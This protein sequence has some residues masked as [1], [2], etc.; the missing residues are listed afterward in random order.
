MK[1]WYS[2]GKRQKTYDRLVQKL[3]PD[4]GEAETEA[5]EM[6]RVMGNVVYDVGNNGGCNFDAGG[7]RRSDLNSF[8]DFLKNFKFAQADSLREQL[9]GLSVDR[10]NT[11]GS[12]CECY[13]CND[14]E[15]PPA[16]DNVLFD[17]ACDLIVER[18]AKI[19]KQQKRKAA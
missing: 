5:G 14:Y 19:D 10:P 12:G 1:Y 9:I 4:V 11:H 2:N 7:G 8:T 15:E 3:V 6:L 18:A 16:L 17:A 13:E